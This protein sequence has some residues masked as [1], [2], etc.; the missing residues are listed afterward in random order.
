MEQ[1]EWGVDHRDRPT[2]F[3]VV[4]DMLYCKE[5]AR[6]DRLYSEARQ[7]PVAVRLVL[8]TEM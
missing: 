1:G 5:I 4:K 2:L 6:V 7:H 3:T 8:S